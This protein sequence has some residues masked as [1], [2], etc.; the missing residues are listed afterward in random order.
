MEE[1]V[2]HISDLEGLNSELEG[3]LSELHGREEGLSSRV[4]T[5]EE[6]LAGACTAAD[7]AMGRMAERR[8][9]RGDR[10][11]PPSPRR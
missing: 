5:L 4:K 9:A 7:A 3:F 11:R 8:P 2:S 1:Q 10:Q 6:Q